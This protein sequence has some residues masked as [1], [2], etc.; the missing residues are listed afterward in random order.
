MRKFPVNSAIILG[1][2]TRKW[3][4]VPVFHVL[5]SFFGLPLM[6]LGIV[7]LTQNS[8]VGMTA[9][10]I[11][12]LVVIGIL[13]FPI[14]FWWFFGSGKNRFIE[15]FEDPVG[16]M[17]DDDDNISFDENNSEGTSIG[18]GSSNGESPV[19]Y[20]KKQTNNY[21]NRIQKKIF[22]QQ[23][24]RENRLRNVI[25]KKLPPKS[26]KRL[27][28]TKPIEPVDTTAQCCTEVNLEGCGIGV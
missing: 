23:N 9:L 22:A 13:V 24:S 17:S 18:G 8:N 7:A 16:E 2:G 1:I 19:K 14:L 6:F 25:P 21:K 4:I 5:I 3:R 10:G 28:K 20:M 12:I 27:K 15:Y 26:K 11:I